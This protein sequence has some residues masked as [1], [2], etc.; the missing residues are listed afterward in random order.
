ATKLSESLLRGENLTTVVCEPVAEEI[1]KT[2]GCIPFYIHHMIIIFIFNFN[3]WAILFFLSQAV[4]NF[5]MS[6]HPVSILI[7]IRRN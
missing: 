7:H 1:A 2:F 3:S 4:T 6:C 5:Q